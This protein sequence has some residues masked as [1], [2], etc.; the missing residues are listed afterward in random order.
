MEHK[1]WDI[2]WKTIQFEGGNSATHYF[3][4]MLIQI[5]VSLGVAPAPIT[6]TNN[7]VSIG[8]N[9]QS[10]GTVQ[11]HNINVNNAPNGANLHAKSEVVV[12]HISNISKEKRVCLL[13]FDSDNA[14][15]CE[16]SAFRSVLWDARLENLVA[17][18]LLL[19]AFVGQDSGTP[20]WLPDPDEIIELPASYDDH[21][22]MNAIDDIAKYA[23]WKQWC[24]T[25]EAA[26]TFAKGLIASNSPKELHA[27]FAAVQLK[28]EQWS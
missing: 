28:M 12:S 22:A 7:T 9:V 15:H 5:E 1:E 25:E 14:D 8:N 17:N 13:F 23:M 27:K 11:F 26:I 24:A 3:A 6:D 19:I 20:N 10:G 16:L 4:D 21:S 2:P 18:G